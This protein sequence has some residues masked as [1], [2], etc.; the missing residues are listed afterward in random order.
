MARLMSRLFKET[1]SE[2]Q[3][4]L[5]L[6]VIDRDPDPLLAGE[7]L[8]PRQPAKALVVLAKLIDPAHL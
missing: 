3:L 2:P 7:F 5:V 1:D 8:I 6:F 4:S